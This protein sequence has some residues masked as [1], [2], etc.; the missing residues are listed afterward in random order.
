MRIGRRFHHLVAILLAALALGACSA[1]DTVTFRSG[2]TDSPTEIAATLRL[3]DGDGPFPAV[4]LLHG[5]SGLER[6]RDGV[7]Y[8]GLLAH[9]D[10]LAEAGFASLIVDSWG[11]RGI[12]T[13]DAYALRCQGRFAPARQ[14]DL[15]GAIRY[16]RGRGDISEAIGVL[17]LSQGGRTAVE[18]SAWRR[19]GIRRQVPKAAV[20]LYPSCRTAP[21]DVAMPLLILTGGSDFIAPADVCR[22]WLDRYARTRPLTDPDPNAAPVPVPELVVYPGV[23]HGFDLPI[24]GAGQTPLGTVRADTRATRDARARMIAFFRRYLVD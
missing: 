16:L 18:A 7:P 8:R 12:A 10:A 20:A 13:N 17:G 1:T 3:P 15:S 6:D 5:C 24:E 2:P 14:A 11:S 22:T 9:Q 23:F 19:S 21:G 4:V